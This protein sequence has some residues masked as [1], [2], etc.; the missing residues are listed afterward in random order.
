MYL[1]GNLGCYSIALRAYIIKDVSDIA[2]FRIKVKG[3]RISKG[4]ES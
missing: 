2:G 4:S 3:I 1:V